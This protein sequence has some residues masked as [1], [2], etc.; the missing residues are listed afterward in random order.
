MSTETVIVRF[1]GKAYAISRKHAAM[2][3]KRRHL[4]R[5]ALGRIC[6]D[7]D[8]CIEVVGEPIEAKP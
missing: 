3:V 5:D 8:R 6:M 1:R 7:E 4:H 2:L